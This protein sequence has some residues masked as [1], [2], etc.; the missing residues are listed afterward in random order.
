MRVG[1]VFVTGVGIL[2][3]SIA[4]GIFNLVS[5]AGLISDIRPGDI[6]I[7][8]FI[9]ACISGFAYLSYFKG[10]ELTNTST[11]SVVFFLKA[12]TATVLS[13]LIL[14]DAPSMSTYIGAAFILAGTVVLIISN[15]R[16][17][18]PVKK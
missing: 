17:S 6:P 9:G 16:K 10:M 13:I 1:T 4:L 2:F 7:I 5:G 11:G 15:N 8:L 12:M 18:S 14:K 3:G